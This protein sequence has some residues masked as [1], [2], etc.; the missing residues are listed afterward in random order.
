[1][2]ATDQ[3][4]FKNNNKKEELKKIHQALQGSKCLLPLLFT[5]LTLSLRRNF[6]HQFRV[7]WI[8]A[9]EVTLYL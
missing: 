9:I 2:V 8:K 7:G 1:M 5:F 3:Q 6:K 4:K